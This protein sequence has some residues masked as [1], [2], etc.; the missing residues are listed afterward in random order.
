MREQRLLERIRA[1]QEA[2]LKR[3][4]EDPKQI[5]DSV[6]GHLQRILNTRQGSVPI[7]EDFGLP[8]LTE[9][10]Q[11]YPDSLIW[12]ERAIRQTIQKY[13]PRLKAVRVKFVPYDDDP[14]SLRFQIVG[15]LV[16]EDYKNPV[17]F[18]SV[19]GSDGKIS[20]KR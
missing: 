8:D 20:I 13:E 11:D 4:R 5:I 15:K 12:F 16:T 2:P 1:W 17:H 9:L 3:T 14:L 10:H 18:E 7:A 6:L 19:V